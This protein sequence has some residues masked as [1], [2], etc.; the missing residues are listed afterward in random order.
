MQQEIKIMANKNVS[1]L[2]ILLAILLLVA[3]CAGLQS[4]YTLPVQHPG[5]AELGAAPKL[6]M[7]CHKAGGAVPY[8]RY[9]HTADFGQNHRAEAYQGEAICA[10]CHQ[11]SF[12]NDCHAT[13]IELKPSLKNQ[14]ETYR[15]SPHR[16]DYLSRHRIDGRIDP[17]SCFRCHGNPKAA[18]TC[19]RCH[20]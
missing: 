10:M 18:Q 13:R 5:A 9:V 12:C 15:S 17:T 6:C 4:S 14:S 8:Q 3:A 11:T 7:D 19:V 16:G 2:L 20:G 1:S